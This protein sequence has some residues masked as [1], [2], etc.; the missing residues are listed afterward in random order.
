[1]QKLSTQNF[2]RQKIPVW[3]EVNHT[4]NLLGVQDKQYP[5]SRDASRRVKA[6]ICVAV[7]HFPR[8]FTATACGGPKHIIDLDM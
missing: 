3:H 8:L 4:N 2:N 7:F 5:P 1:M 6:T